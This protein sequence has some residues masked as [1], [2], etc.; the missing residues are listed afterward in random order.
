M[1]HSRPIGRPWGLTTGACTVVAAAWLVGI[2]SVGVG[3][4]KAKTSPF[5]Y[6]ADIFPI[7]R[8]NCGTCH[9]EGG[10]A[11]MSLMT[12]DTDGGAV[13]WAE[14]IR[15]ML[16][17][18]AM[19]PWYAD[20]AGPAV[21]N[22]HRLTAR[23]LDK[24]ITWATG[25]TPHG[26]LALKLPKVVVR[27]GWARGEPDATLPAPE[28]FTVAAHVMQASHEVTIPTHFTQARWVRAADLLPGSAAM[29]RR[30]YISVE[31]GPMLAVWEPGSD[32]VDAPHDTAFQ[33]PANASLHLKI[34]YKKGW[35]DEQSALEDKSV[36][37]LYFAQPPSGGKSIQ[38]VTIH[39]TPSSN[40]FTGAVPM[41]GRVVALRPM[42]D[43]AYATVDITAIDRSGKTV[44]LLK[45]RNPRPEWPRR[46]WLEK[47]I[48][49]PAGSTVTVKT[50]AGDPDIGPLGKVEAFPL[51]IDLD[52]VPD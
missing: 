14:S 34:D 49:V 41:A 36:V 42:L 46:Y 33:V 45:L 3:A 35:Q 15:E 4:H 27:H 18:G 7:L 19:P 9:V 29:V 11:P 20:P 10:P 8:D 6:N 44:S 13:A 23:E 37:G 28:P 24:V 50:T 31:G 48:P 22:N 25:G 12:Y 17:S 21:R 26:D 2:T 39:G 1:R 47:P 32:P 51:Q 16:L 38:S 5:S 30:A 43:N 40:Q 52:V